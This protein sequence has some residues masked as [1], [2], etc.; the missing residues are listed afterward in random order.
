MTTITYRTAGT[1]GA[2]KGANLTAAEIDG[3][4]HAL[5]TRLKDVED[6]PVQPVEI[7]SIVSNGA[8]LTITLSDGT[9]YGPL[10]IGSAALVYRGAWA[11]ATAYTKNDIVVVGSAVYYV[12]VDHTSAAPFDGGRIIGGLPVYKI[13][14][15]GYAAAYGAV[16]DA[17]QA[18]SHS[19]IDFNIG[20]DGAV[21]AVV[22]FTAG[23]EACRDAIAAA[24]TTQASTGIN[25]WHDD[26]GDAIYAVV[27][28][29]WVGE[30]SLDALA[31]ALVRGTHV[32]IGFVYD[33]EAA[34]GLGSLSATVLV[35]FTDLAQTPNSL[36]G[37]GRKLVAVAQDE[38]GVEF[39]DPN[40]LV[41]VAAVPRFM[42]AQVCLSASTSAQNYSA[43]IAIPFAAEVFDTDGFH[44]S[45][46]NN[47]RLTIP[48]GLGIRKVRV[49]ATVRVSSITAG[50]DNYLS[51]RKNAS[52]IY[53]GAPALHHE[54][55]AATA[56]TIS[57]TSGPIPVVA[58]DWFDCWFST[59][60]TSTGLEADRTTF[61]IEVLEVEGGINLASVQ[62][63]ATTARTLG[64]ADINGHL[65]F[66]S[67]SPVGVTVPANASVAFPV[68]ASVDLEQSGAGQ[69]TVSGAPGVTVNKPASKAAAT[70]SRYSVIRLRKVAADTWTLFG[71]LA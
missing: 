56:T 38:T 28:A 19:G 13:M 68:G 41:P 32:G 22:D 71:D 45:V 58:G 31:A 53:I 63:D 23:A 42:G 57:V 29:G 8:T 54:N 61:S 12:N 44:D 67:G 60:D 37:Q 34:V 69:V 62:N 20:L 24:L 6:S 2:G 48:A 39:V 43:G 16:G 18:G 40:Q 33:D 30:V 66:A 52:D 21:S 11:A 49:S 26:A 65:V 27:D 55:S 46:T 17:L 64:L 10:A 47:A 35:S 14:F 59:S 5:D 9:V 4:F 25:F 50:S 1:W 3:N 36:V 15:D 70:A 51:I 7:E